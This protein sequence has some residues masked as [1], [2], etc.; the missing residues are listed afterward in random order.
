MRIR[1]SHEIELEK[2]EPAWMAA[3]PV[4]AEVHIG[5]PRAADLVRDEHEHAPVQAA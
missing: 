3:K 1:R 4:W 5:A 2:P